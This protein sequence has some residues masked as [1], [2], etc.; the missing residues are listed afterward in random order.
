MLEAS[1]KSYDVT[2]EKI[3]ATP[4]KK[5]VTQVLDFVLERLK[6]YYQPHGYSVAQLAAVL[7]CRPTKPLDFDRRLKALARF[8][9]EQA[10]AAESLAAA[11]KRIKNI[12]AKADDKPPKKYDATLFKHEEEN[13]LAR[14][15]ETIGERVKKYF[16]RNQYDDGFA[17]LAEL[18]TPVDA[19]FD[20]V[21]VMEKDAK[22]RNNRLALLAQ[23]R[24]LFLD[25]AD[26]SH[27]GGER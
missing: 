5:T 24:A 16:V 21:M 14:Q 4:D 22:I 10:D 18:K 26:I 13:E 17:A 2:D 6:S 19:F 12:L 15:L 11:N 23:I 27:L 20:G 3:A 8:F 7:A 25:A 9:T 1:R